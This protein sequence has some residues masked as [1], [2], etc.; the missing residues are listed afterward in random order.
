MIDAE[1]PDDG[2]TGGIIAFR[3]LNPVTAGHRLLVPKR[4]ISSSSWTP[5]VTGSVFEAAARYARNRYDSF[6]LITSVG[7][8]AT[9]TVEHLHVHVVP[10]W[11]GDGLKLPWSDQLPD[12]VP[13]GLRAR[14]LRLAAR[15]GVSVRAW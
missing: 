4:H 14:L 7:A 6:N 12:A 10:R 1:Y 5:M 15:G 11:P 8:P 2:H 13:C 3:P 9:Q